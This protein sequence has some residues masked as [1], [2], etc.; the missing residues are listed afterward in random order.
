MRKQPVDESI[1]ASHGSLY[2][3]ENAGSRSAT[4]FEQLRGT[5]ESPAN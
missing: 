4:N 5:V 3:E 1:A 2:S